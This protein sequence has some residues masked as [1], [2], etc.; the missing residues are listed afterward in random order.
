M[1]R[2]HDAYE[3]RAALEGRNILEVA[4]ATELGENLREWRTAKGLSLRAAA[5]ELG[6][7]YSVLQKLETGGR[8]KT[9]DVDFLERVA[10]V[11]SV[12]TPEVLAAAGYSLRHVRDV[13][14]VVDFAFRDLVLNP[15]LCPT[16]MDPAWLDSFS[17]KQK[18]QWLE[19]AYNL[20][21][22][23]ETE[24]YDPVDREVVRMITGK[25]LA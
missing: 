22:F 1:P 5:V 17:T 7:P 14:D 3:L 24:G 12:P 10:L 8:A 9:P 11:Y 20:F 2:E 13:R 18:G 16:G 23:Y 19:F 15:R 21:Q 4:H 6:L 25:E